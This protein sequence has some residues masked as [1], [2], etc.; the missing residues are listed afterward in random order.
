MR[1]LAVESSARAASAALTENGRIMSECYSDAGLTHSRT[2]LPMVDAVM[3]AADTDI[4]SVDC[5]AVTHGPGSFTGVR[6]GVA[7]V[8]GMADALNKPCIGL[9]TLEVT[10]YNLRGFECTAACAMDAR[11]SQIYTALFSCGE[12]IER[13]SEDEALPISGLIRRL[14]EIKGTIYLVGDGARLV[15]EQTELPNVLL[16]APHVL[17]QRAGCA[18]LCA[19]ERLL[20]QQPVSAGELVP[21]YLRM[22]QAQR[23]LK[24][25]RDKA[26]LS[27]IKL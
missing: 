17:L 2:L 22:P 23:E 7:A 4:K 3:R 13:I 6:I 18:G 26:G 5:F 25:K 21:V 15:K 27:E 24:M 19:Q 9:S 10:A 14:E 16:A 20:T 11:C 12:K 8:K 1:I